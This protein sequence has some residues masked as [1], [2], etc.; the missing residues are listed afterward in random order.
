MED[1]NLIITLKLKEIL[2]KNKIMSE[3]IELIINILQTLVPNVNDIA[4]RLTSLER[5]H[6]KEIFLN[7]INTHN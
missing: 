7:E 6:D 3:S 4:F 1:D 5:L 2:I